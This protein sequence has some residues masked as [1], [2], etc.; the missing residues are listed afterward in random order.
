MAAVTNDSIK[1]IVT[2]QTDELAD[3]IAD[4]LAKLLNPLTERL[5]ECEKSLGLMIDHA[6]FMERALIRYTE[7]AHGGEGPQQPGEDSEAWRE[8]LGDCE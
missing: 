7:I 3:A 8:S 1:Q 6:T 4:V 5:T 2:Q